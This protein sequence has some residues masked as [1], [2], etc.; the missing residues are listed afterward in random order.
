VQ[1]FKDGGK[2]SQADFEDLF[3]KIGIDLPSLPLE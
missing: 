3:G 1:W 2:I